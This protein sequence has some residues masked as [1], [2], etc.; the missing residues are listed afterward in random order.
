MEEVAAYVKKQVRLAK[1]NKNGPNVVTPLSAADEL[2]KYK[3]LLDAGVI[4]QEEFDKKKK[5]LLNS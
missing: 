2:K 4:T 3:D 5:Q 1:K